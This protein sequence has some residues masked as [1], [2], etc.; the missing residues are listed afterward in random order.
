MAANS[1]LFSQRHRRSIL[2]NLRARQDELLEERPPEHES[3]SEIVIVDPPQRTTSGSRFE[4]KTNSVEGIINARRP[5]TPDDLAATQCQDTTHAFRDSDAVKPKLVDRFFGRKLV[6]RKNGERSCVVLPTHPLI[7]L[8]DTITALTLFVVVV[9][10]PIEVPHRAITR[11][12]P[13]RAAAAVE[14]TAL[15]CGTPAACRWRPSSSPP[16]LL[17]ARTKPPPSLLGCTPH[18]RS[19]SSPLP[20]APPSPS[21]SS[22]EPST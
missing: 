3:E 17:H 6:A 20:Q 12:A 8:W 1:N 18:Y 13:A 19:L 14:V 22:A 4:H 11:H 9:V 16:L 7:D 10:V 21:S 5:S 15:L 2:E